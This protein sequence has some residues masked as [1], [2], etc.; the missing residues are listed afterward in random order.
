LYASPFASTSS[1]APISRSY[2]SLCERREGQ[3]KFNQAELELTTKEL[4]LHAAQAKFYVAEYKLFK[5]DL[6]ALNQDLKPLKLYPRINDYFTDSEYEALRIEQVI[7]A[8]E[9]DELSR[10][11]RSLEGIY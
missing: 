9:V 5:L 2:I 11:M 6:E 10:R 3:D 1:P 8:A 7:Q 4:E